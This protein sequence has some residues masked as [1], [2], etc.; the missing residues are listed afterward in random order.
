MWNSFLHARI[1]INAANQ[2]HPGH[3]RGRVLGVAFMRATRRRKGTTWSASTTSSRAKRRTSPTCW[4]CRTSIWFGTTSPS[5]SSLEVDEI[6]NLACP[7]APGHYQYNPIKTMKTSVMGAINMLGWRSAAGRRF[8]RLPPAK[9][10]ATRRVHPQPENVSRGSK[11][12]RAASLLRR[13]QA[14]GRN[15]V[16][17]LLPDTPAQCAPR[18]NLQHLRP[19]DASLRRPR[20]VELHSPSALQARRSPFLATAARHVRFAIATISSKACCE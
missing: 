11:P 8:C 19:A 6:Y 17:G 15:I 5:R 3:R 9:F 20:G 13:G 12:S 7:A 14:G 10:M 16:Y 1:G 4:T 18:A 2:P